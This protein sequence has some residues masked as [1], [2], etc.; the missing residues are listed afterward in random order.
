MLGTIDAVYG[1][2]GAIYASRRGLFLSSVVH[3][4][5]W[6]AGTA[7]VLIHASDGAADG[8]R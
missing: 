5:G 7:E 6:L 3:M 8:I 4:L 2:L 1:E